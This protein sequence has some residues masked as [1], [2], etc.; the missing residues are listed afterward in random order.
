MRKR[1]VLL[2]LCLALFSTSKIHGQSR[3]TARLHNN[4]IHTYAGGGPD[5][6]PALSANIPVP[7]AG[8]AGAAR[9]NF[10]PTPGGGRGFLVETTG[11]KKVVG[12]SGGG[13]LH[14]GG[15]PGKKA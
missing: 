1:N 2:I 9:K 5:G 8:G 10:I 12:G 3:A 4:K 11:K 7:T 15:G 14:G 13:R 6:I